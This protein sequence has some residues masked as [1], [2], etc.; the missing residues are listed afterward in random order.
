V[1]QP[2]RRRTSVLFCAVLCLV[3]VSVGQLPPSEIFRRVRP[4][5]VLIYAENEAGKDAVQGSGFIVANNRVVTNYHVVAGTSK[6]YVIFSDGA[7]AQI[8]GVIAESPSKDLIAL[9]VDTGSRPALTLGDEMA[10]REGDPVLAMGSPEGLQF[11][12]TDG[13]VSGFRN[14]G[15]SF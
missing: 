5:T 6:A 9:N 7:L 11:S 13:I 8:S 15:S 3:Q 12:I 14:L 4:S 1:N 10:L 2:S